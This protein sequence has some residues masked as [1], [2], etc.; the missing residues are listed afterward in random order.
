[1]SLDKKTIEKLKDKLLEQEAKLKKELDLI[2]VPIDDEG[3]YRAKYEDI[4]EHK[5]EN[6]TEVEHYVE[7]IALKKNL[8]QQLKNTESAL[9]KIEE[10]TYGIC[11]ECG[12]EIRK[13]RL[14]INPAAKRCMKCAR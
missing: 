12:G 2:A 8:E 3:D 1:M 5:D 7:K 4:G 13:E 10:G 6:A 9:K 14:E 11:E